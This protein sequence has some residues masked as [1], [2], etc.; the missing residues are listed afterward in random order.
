[1]VDTT[2][3]T[4]SHLPGTASI[5]QARKKKP[6]N[7]REKESEWEKRDGGLSTGCRR[8]RQNWIGSKSIVLRWK[9]L[10][11]RSPVAGIGNLVIGII[12]NEWHISLICNGSKCYRST[13]LVYDS[14]TIYSLPYRIET[15]TQFLGGECQS[16]SRAWILFCLGF[17]FVF[18]LVM[19]GSSK[20]TIIRIDDN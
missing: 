20:L 6:R 3:G 4:H 11:P 19:S 9:T 14:M 17:L 7:R 10:S 16:M 15:F 13:G 8:K 12:L 2:C 5:N 1:M 18:T